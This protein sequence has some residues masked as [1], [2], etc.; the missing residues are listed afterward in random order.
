MNLTYAK[1]V[2][3]TLVSRS[4]VFEKLNEPVV[5]IADLI[6]TDISE[7]LPM[8]NCPTALQEETQSAPSILI[9]DDDPIFCHRV[10]RIAR[11][12]NL[13]VTVCDSLAKFTALPREL[14]F[15]VAI[16][17]YYF[18]DITA[19]QISHLLRKEIPIV[20]MSA[21]SGSLNLTTALPKGTKKVLSKEVGVE[22]IIDEALSTL[23]LLSRFSFLPRM[24][25]SE[26][27]WLA[28][29]RNL[30]IAVVASLWL[31]VAFSLVYRA[32]DH[33]IHFFDSPTETF[34]PIAKHSVPTSE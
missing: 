2:D 21:F 4:N 20:V 27:S 3:G 23:S 16:L 15:D 28:S 30:V 12:M 33:K 5:S 9:V 1:I 17:D 31:A 14:M 7:W 13:S 11:K 10:A 6:G 8:S 19:N 24:M 26:N 29:K 22:K 32:S 25:P 18:G 34:G